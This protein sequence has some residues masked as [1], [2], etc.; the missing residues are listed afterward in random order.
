[1]PLQH[2]HLVLLVL[3]VLLLMHLL[4]MMVEGVLLLLMQLKLLLL[5]L[6]LLLWRE[7]RDVL[8]ALGRVV[9]R[10]QLRVGMHVRMRVEVRQ[11]L[12]VLLRVLWL[13]G[14]EL[15]MNVRMRVLVLVL[16]LGRHLRLAVLVGVGVVALVL[17]LGEL[18]RMHLLALLDLPPLGRALVVAA[19]GC[20]DDVGRDSRHA[21]GCSSNPGRLRGTCARGLTTL[22]LRPLEAKVWVP[23]ALRVLDL[24]PLK[25]PP[26]QKVKVSQPTKSAA[27]ERKRTKAM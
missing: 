18:R 26:P 7:L 16:V 1:L 27:K 17:V 5:H 24:G 8:D 19:A 20:G 13:L 10:G 11:M 23:L 14:R 3:L 25:K 9:L 21:R 12:H 4:V 2:H 15:W 6:Q 22:R